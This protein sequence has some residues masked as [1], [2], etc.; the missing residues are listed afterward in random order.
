MKLAGQGLK[1]GVMHNKNKGRDQASS[2]AKQDGLFLPNFCGVHAVFAVVVGGQ[3]LAFLLVLARASHSTNP[4]GDLGLVSLFVQWVGLSAALLLCLARPVLERLGNT[5]AGLASYGAVLAITLLLSEAA[6]RIMGDVSLGSE[7]LAGWHGEFLVRNLAIGAIVSAVA[8]RYLYVQHQW[9]C[10][11]EIEARARFQALQARIRPHFLFNSM[12][13][14]ASL[15]RSRPDLAEGAVE[16]LA[17]LFRAALGDGREQVTLAEELEFTRRYLNIEKLRLGERLTVVWEVD[18]LP[19]DV[20]LPALT[21]QPLLENAVY[22][23]IGSLSDGGTLGISGQCE[24]GLLSLTVRN[25]VATEADATPR[26]GNRMA[27]E[28]IRQR[29]EALYGRQG[30]L[31]TRYSENQFHVT[32]SI[33]CAKRSA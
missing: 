24:N 9:R 1:L 2:K 16:D 18:A 13:T 15:T 10:N 3:L 20:T 23:G 29:L 12:N 31:D 7:T 27:L 26:A 8:L 28:N 30:R 11:V 32:V 33:P 17:D 14:I 21:L 5:G 4:W 22:H 19:M 6:Y 25:P